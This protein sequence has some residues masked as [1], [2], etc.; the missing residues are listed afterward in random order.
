MIFDCLSYSFE[1]KSMGFYCEQFK[2][3]EF[4]LNDGDDFM[5]I[6]F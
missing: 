2:R 1:G 6:W 3:E 4:Q 5:D